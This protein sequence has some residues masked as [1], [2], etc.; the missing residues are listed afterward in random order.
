MILR[1]L[2]FTLVEVVI[3]LGVISFALVAIL[4]LFPVAMDA[5]KSSRNETRAAAIAQY[6]FEQLNTQQPDRASL[7]L[8]TNAISTAPTDGNQL[9]NLTTNTGVQFIR[10]VAYNESGD[11]IRQ[12]NG[13]DY[14]NAVIPSAAPTTMFKTR[15][16]YYTNQPVQGVAHVVV[17][18]SYPATAHFTN[19]TVQY[20][21][22]YL[23]AKKP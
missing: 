11:P 7:P 12:L 15:F 3:A 16:T 8:G 23:S 1:R 18:V 10:F 6:I 17:E 9:V 21:A 14:T 19:R 13:T 22:S 5:A 20:F 2:G 4:G